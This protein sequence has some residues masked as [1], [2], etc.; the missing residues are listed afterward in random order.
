MHTAAGDR[1]RR[2]LIQRAARKVFQ[3]CSLIKFPGRAASIATSGAKAAASIASSGAKAAWITILRP[4]RGS[5]DI[6]GSSTN[7]TGSRT[8]LSQPAVS[9][10][11]I[12]SSAVTATL[13]TSANLTGK[14]SRAAAKS[15]PSLTIIP[16]IAER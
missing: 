6:T 4:Y 9:D 8:K 11:Y 3:V 10:P 12:T 15:V 7:I 1:S 16:I 14:P 13:P 5:G 2:L